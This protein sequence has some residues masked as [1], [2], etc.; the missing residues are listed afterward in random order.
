VSANGR[1]KPTRTHAARKAA[2]AAREAKD[3]PR[4]HEA[5]RA[6][7]H[8]GKEAPDERTRLLSLDDLDMRLIATKKAFAI[9]RGIFSDLGGEDRLSTAERQLAQRAAMLG[10]I[11]EDLEARWVRGDKID[12]PTYHAAVNTQRRVLTSLGLARKLRDITPGDDLQS[13]LAERDDTS[14]QEE[15]A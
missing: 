12:H 15:A 7:V 9:K 10:A 2:R 6:F 11:C 1:T 13:Y 14:D 5:A 4:T 3:A 8:S